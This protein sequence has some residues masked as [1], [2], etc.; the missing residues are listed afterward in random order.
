MDTGVGPVSERMLCPFRK[1]KVAADVAERPGCY[2]VT[3]WEEHFMECVN[4][5]CT[6]WQ[7]GC[8]SLITFVPNPKE[9][10]S[11]ETEK[12]KQEQ[13]GIGKAEEK[14][15]DDG[16]VET[17]VKVLEARETKNSGSVRAWCQFEDGHK[18]AIFAKNG[19]GRVLLESVGKEVAAKYRRMNNGAL[20]AVFVVE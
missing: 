12:N 16:L 5:K 18:E 7:N 15:N 8:C 1:R 11:Q 3:Q 13:A 17:V 9:Q 19:A 14:R 10:P 4:E 2:T 6:A 20:F